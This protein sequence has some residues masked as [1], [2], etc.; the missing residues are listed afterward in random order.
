MEEQEEAEAPAKGWRLQLFHGIAF[1]EVSLHLKARCALFST[2]HRILG[3][4]GV[5]K[6][7]RLIDEESSPEKASD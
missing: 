5:L 7:S 6:L 2:G 3:L 4:E 1:L